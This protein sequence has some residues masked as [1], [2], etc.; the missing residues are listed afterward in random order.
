MLKNNIISMAQARVVEKYIDKSTGKHKEE[1]QTN[2]FV[3]SPGYSSIRM[4]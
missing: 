1:R 2:I 3:G 4:H